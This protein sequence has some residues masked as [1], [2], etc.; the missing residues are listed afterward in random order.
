M[1]TW[2]LIVFITGAVPAN[3]EL[4]RVYTVEYATQE[5]CNEAGKTAVDSFTDHFREVKYVCTLSTH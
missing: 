4:G 2:V 3:S 5:Q 1:A